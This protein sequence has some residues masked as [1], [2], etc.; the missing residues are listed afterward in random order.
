[1][2]IAAFPDTP[3][4]I[5]LRHALI[6]RPAARLMRVTRGDAAV[7]VLLMMT[8]AMVT[9]VG[10]GDGIG[11]LAMGAPDIAVWITTFEVSAYV[12]V[13]IALGA[14]A[15]G[16]HLRGAIA[17]YAGIFARGGRAR[18]TDRARRSRKMRPSAA[19]NDDE[20]GLLARVA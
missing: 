19:D 16:L 12:D 15:S 20:P 17:R 10:E 7:M 8:A 13:I 6:D 9:L 1:M 14:A 18:A 2:V 4:G 5:A 11:M 3:I